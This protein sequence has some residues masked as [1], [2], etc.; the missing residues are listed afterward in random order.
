[1]NMSLVESQHHNTIFQFTHGVKF[2]L[3]A[4]STRHK[5]LHVLTATSG[6]CVIAVLAVLERS[7]QTSTFGDRKK[8]S[9][10]PGEIKN[11]IFWDSGAKWAIMPATLQSLLRLHRISVTGRTYPTLHPRQ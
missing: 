4:L 11:H 6:A 9:L 7:G 2:A 3:Y 10:V 8:R 5:V 1:M